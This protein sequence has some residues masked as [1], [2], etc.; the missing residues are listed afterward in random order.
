[1]T[2]TPLL[3]DPVL[4]EKFKA[5]DRIE[6]NPKTNLYSYKVRHKILLSI[7]PDVLFASMNTIS[8]IRPR[9]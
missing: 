8:G 7:V 3:E 2:N 4:L 5:H 9:C 1:L 6:Y